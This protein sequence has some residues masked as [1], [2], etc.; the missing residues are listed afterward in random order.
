MEQL[1]KTSIEVGGWS[2]ESRK[3]FLTSSDP[4]SQDIGNKFELIENE[5]SAV[6]RVANGTFCYYENSFLLR[7]VRGE[8][9]SEND[10]QR[11]KSD[12]DT[13]STVKY[14]LHIMEECVVYMPIALGLEK[15]SPLKPHVD[16]WVICLIL[17]IQIKNMYSSTVLNKRTE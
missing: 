9:I 8:R 11:N 5:E 10:E 17:W 2:E 7:H 14:D 16:L 13:D 15:N 12:T 3:F 4:Y 1:S 6:D